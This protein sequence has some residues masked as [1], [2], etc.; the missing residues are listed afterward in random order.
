MLP[1]KQQKLKNVFISV[2]ILHQKNHFRYF[3]VEKLKANIFG[4]V[5]SQKKEM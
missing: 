2:S 5:K 3:F 1:E 4:R